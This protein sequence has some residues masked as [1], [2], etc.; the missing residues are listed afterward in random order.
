MFIVAKNP[1]TMLIEFESLIKE[2][3]FFVDGKSNVT[4]YPLYEVEVFKQYVNIPIYHPSERLSMEGIVCNTWNEFMLEFQ[5]MIVNHYTPNF[6]LFTFSETGFKSLVFNA[7]DIPIYQQYSKD[8]LLEME[9]CN[10]KELGR[11]YGIGGRDRNVLVNK[12][13]SAQENFHG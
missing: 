5:R 4:S 9:W 3:Y 7:I 6:N 12:I 11:L 8:D 2:G 13:L 10:L 1:V